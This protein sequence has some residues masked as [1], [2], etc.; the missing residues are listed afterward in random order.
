MTLLDLWKIERKENNKRPSPSN[1]EN[2][3]TTMKKKKYEESRVCK[4]NQAWKKEFPWVEF[5]EAENEMFCRL[6][7]KY[8][9]VC[10]KSSH[11]F[12]GIDHSSLTGFCRES[13]ISHNSNQCHYFCFKRGKNETR[14]EQA[15]LV[16]M[17]R[18]ID[19]E[20]QERLETLFNTAHFIEKE[21]L[22]L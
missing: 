13:L 16:R 15:P 18:K 21:K 17:N 4:F 5:D 1:E 9:S 6:C 11:L 2:I 22:A 12:L 8:P 7:R 10:D 3:S 19:K 14:P 20:S